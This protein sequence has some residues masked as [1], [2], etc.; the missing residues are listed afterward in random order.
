MNLNSL[1]SN[2]AQNQ[3]SGLHNLNSAGVKNMLENNEDPLKADQIQFKALGGVRPLKLTEVDTGVPNG[4]LKS[5]NPYYSSGL[6]HSKCPSTKRAGKRCRRCKSK[7]SH[8]EGR[9]SNIS[10]FL[11]IFCF[12]CGLLSCC[13]CRDEVSVCNRC[14]KELSKTLWQN[15]K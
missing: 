12:P 14:G 9:V 8:L 2:N 7:A 11:S 15:K 1:T 3:N 10:V 13:F 4:K 6:V 5:K